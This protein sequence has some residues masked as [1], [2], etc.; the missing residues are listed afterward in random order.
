MNYSLFKC[1][2]SQ[3]SRGS[4]S[5]LIK[6]YNYL[7]IISKTF[8]LSFVNKSCNQSDLNMTFGITVTGARDR[9]THLCQSRTSP[10]TW[11]SPGCC[12][13]SSRSLSAAAPAEPSAL[14]AP[15]ADAP[16]AAR[17]AHP[18]PAASEKG[19]KYRNPRRDERVSSFGQMMLGI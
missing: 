10:T 19:N 15:I 17:L 12:S 14:S 8:F 5:A 9:T 2:L 11:R 4:E 7:I 18:A 3:Q 6:D 16:S 13:A 1:Q